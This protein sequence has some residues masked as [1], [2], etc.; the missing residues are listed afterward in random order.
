VLDVI[1]RG[2]QH[3]VVDAGEAPF[4]FLRVE[5]RIGPVDRD[6]RNVDVR[7]NI[8]GRCR[9]GDHTHDENEQCEHDECV[10]PVQGYTN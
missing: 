3:A 7:K 6:H 10:G 9:N 1:D 5:S 8:S 4:Q 2:G